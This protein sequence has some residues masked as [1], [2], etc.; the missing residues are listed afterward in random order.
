MIEPAKLIE[1]FETI[2]RIFAGERI[3]LQQ[4]RVFPAWRDRGQVPASRLRPQRNHLE[5]LGMKETG[6]Y[7]NSI[8]RQ[9]GQQLFVH[10]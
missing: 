6:I 10:E 5:P 8:R 3:S 9:T 1:S 7:V 2:R 4:L